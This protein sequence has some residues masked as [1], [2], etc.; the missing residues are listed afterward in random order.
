MSNDL[1]DGIEEV[2]RWQARDV[3]ARIMGKMDVGPTGLLLEPLGG[4]TKR[5]C[6][7]AVNGVR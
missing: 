3:A 1:I 7:I 2:R 4:M 5:N 6:L